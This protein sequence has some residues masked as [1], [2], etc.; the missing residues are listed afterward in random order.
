MFPNLVKLAAVPQSLPLTNAWQEWGTCALKRIKTRLRN[1]LKDDMLECLLQ[2]SINGL[3]VSESRDVVSNALGLWLQEKNRKLPPVM[4]TASASTCK[5][6][7][8]FECA[9]PLPLEVP[10]P[11][12]I[13]HLLKMLDRF[14]WERWEINISYSILESHSLKCL[15]PFHLLPEF[16]KMACYYWT[17]GNHFYSH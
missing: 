4:A 5:L 2:V 16:S 12:P 14:L 7:D 8:T 1:S 17:T 9:Q 10:L 15:S 3:L 6:L 11:L 13:W